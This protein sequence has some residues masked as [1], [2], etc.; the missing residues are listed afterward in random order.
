MSTASL[1]HAVFLHRGNRP[2]AVLE[3]LAVYNPQLALKRIRHCTHDI[4]SRVQIYVAPEQWS[5]P[6]RL[7]SAFFGI[8]RSISIQ[9]GERYPWSAD[10]DHRVLTVNT[11]KG[12]D[13]QHV[14]PPVSVS[15]AK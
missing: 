6:L 5:F 4:H 1:P 12:C 14:L 15:F 7:P 13:S 2:L 9:A 3:L 11:S 10:F 8:F